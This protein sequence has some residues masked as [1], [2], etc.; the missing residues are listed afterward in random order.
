MLDASWSD[1][2]QRRLAR[3]LAA[4]LHADVV[5]IRC[6]LPEEIA[7]ERL[8]ARMAAGDDASDATPAIAALM[9]ARSR[10]VA[11]GPHHRL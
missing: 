6:E 11:R 9:A 1:P 4:S 7:I 8:R 5:E 2:D 10:A 3:V